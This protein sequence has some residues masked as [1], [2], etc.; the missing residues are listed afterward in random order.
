MDSLTT[1]HFP[2]KSCELDMVSCPSFLRLMEGD[3]FGQL[4]GIRGF[5]GGY[6]IQPD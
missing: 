1:Q 6:G 3:Q 4:A 5:V 2:E